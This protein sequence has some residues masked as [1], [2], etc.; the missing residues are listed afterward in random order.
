M[1]CQPN[2]ECYNMTDSITFLYS[3][4]HF[5]LYWICFPLDLSVIAKFSPLL[6]EQYNLISLVK[7]NSSLL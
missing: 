6:S 3:N 7:I 5:Q 4:L 1:S 2:C